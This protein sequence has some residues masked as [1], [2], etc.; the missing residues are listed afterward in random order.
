M[1]SKRPLAAH[2]ADVGYADF[3]AVACY[4]SSFRIVTKGF[5]ES[6]CLGL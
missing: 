5:V 3:S 2:C 4:Q 6:A 1:G